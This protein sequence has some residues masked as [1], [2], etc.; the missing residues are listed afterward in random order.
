VHHAGQI[1]RTPRSFLFVDHIQLILANLFRSELIGRFARELAKLVDV[2][3][4]RVDGG[5]GQVSQLH[6][7]DHALDEGIHS[8]L[9]GCHG[10]FSRQRKAEDATTE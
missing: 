2:I 5:V 7:T 8:F 3:G 4:I 9:V 10:M 6:I 1:E